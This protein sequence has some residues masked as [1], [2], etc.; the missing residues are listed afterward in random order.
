MLLAVLLTRIYQV[1]DLSLLYRYTNDLPS[2]RELPTVYATI[3]DTVYMRGN[4]ESNK[5]VI[6]N[7]SRQHMLAIPILFF[8]KRC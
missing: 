5:R 8:G 3:P 4:T 1:L 2:A 7:R 6:E